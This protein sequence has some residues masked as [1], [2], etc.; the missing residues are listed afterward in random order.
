MTSSPPYREP[1]GKNM[2]GKRFANR[3]PA[4]R[5][6]APRPDELQHFIQFFAFGNLPAELWAVSELFYALAQKIADLPSNP[7][8][9]VALRK[10]LESKD[11][12]V[13][14]LARCRA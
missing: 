3:P 5:A 12:A 2:S 14:A 6:D 13:R 4:P 10:L 9:T 1:R 8:R 7:E 11:S